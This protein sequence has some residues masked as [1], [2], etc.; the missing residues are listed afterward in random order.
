MKATNLIKVLRVGFLLLYRGSIWLG[1][2]LLFIT[3]PLWQEINWRYDLSK[4][5]LPTDGS[6]I[7]YD[8]TN[9]NWLG[10][11]KVRP[12]SSAFPYSIT[13]W[14]NAYNID[15]LGRVITSIP[16]AELAQA[17]DSLRQL[18]QSAEIVARRRQAAEMDSVLRANPE[19]YVIK[20]Q[21]DYVLLEPSSFSIFRLR[22]NSGLIVHPQPMPQSD[23][24][25][26]T[27]TTKT[28]EYVMQHNPSIRVKRE[29]DFAT[30]DYLLVF[31]YRT[32]QQFKA[33]PPMAFLL[34]QAS[35]ILFWLAL[36]LGSYQFKRL[37]DD[38]SDSRYFSASQ[39]VRMQRVSRIMI[40]YFIATFLVDNAQNIYVRYY[41]RQHNFYISDRF[42]PF[43]PEHWSIL[44]AGLTLLVFARLFRY[45]HQLQEDAELTI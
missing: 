21:N 4:H 25:N 35:F 29:M 45:G 9:A 43:F 1:G 24:Y 13:K 5:N 6:R 30:K 17:P 36:I 39:F 20:H 44:I 28:W 23:F 27:S 11:L 18:I 41:L 12:Q 33:I 37:F 7:I 3:S 14:D 15:S 8:T 16:K 31:G 26:W 38:L 42:M 32:W 2:L 19:A 22:M 10:I 40:G 34:G